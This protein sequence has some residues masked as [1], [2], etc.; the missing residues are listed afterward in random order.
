MKKLIAIALAVVL[1]LT[2][3]AGTALAEEP[4]HAT[5]GASFVVPTEPYP[6]LSFTF[7]VQ[8]TGGG[9]GEGVLHFFIHGPYVRHLI[10]DVKYCK[11]EGNTAWFA[12]QC[13]HDTY[14]EGLGG[15]QVGYWLVVK[16]VDN[17]E[18]GVGN[19]Y[20]SRVW[21]GPL[22]SQAQVWVNDMCDPE[23]LPH[24]VGSTIETGNLQVHSQ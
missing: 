13:I 2:F 24:G 20:I 1:L 15:I 19:D 7:T 6:R 8:S 4:E 9:S 11:I 21:I 16:A 14:P 5:G 22:E 12:G 18:P 23:D 3:G 10:C 17:G